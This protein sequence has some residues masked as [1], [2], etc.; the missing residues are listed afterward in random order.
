ALFLNATLFATTPLQAL[1][2]GLLGLALAVALGWAVFVAGRQLSVRAF[3][4]ATGVLLLFFAAGLLASGVH[5]LQ[6]AAL[7]PVLVEHVWDLNPVLDEKGPVGG[8][9][10]ALFGY[11][12]DPSLLEVLVYGGYLLMV[13]LLGSGLSRLPHPPRRPIR[14]S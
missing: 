9:L 2:G 14:D 5:E 4:W 11:N 13:G 8:F 10:K 1:I 7:L 6:E 12:G 3:F